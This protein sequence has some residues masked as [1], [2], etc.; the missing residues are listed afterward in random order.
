MKQNSKLNQAIV[1]VSR[2]L[3]P[4]WSLQLGRCQ[5]MAENDTEHALDAITQ[6]QRRINQLRI[7]LPAHASN[8]STLNALEQDLQQ[9]LMAMQ[10][11]DRSKQIL[12]NVCHSIE[13]LAVDYGS[14]LALAEFDADKFVNTTRQRYTT[15]EELE[16]HH[17][18]FPAESSEENS[19]E[20]HAGPDSNQD[21]SKIT[22][23]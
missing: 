5:V 23:F 8:S 15:P 22:L 7:T 4:L 13:Q 20:Q 10:H 3:L 17:T 2:K 11:Q 1:F 18:I 21:G 19:T 16:A 9:L 14:E 6:A 12:A